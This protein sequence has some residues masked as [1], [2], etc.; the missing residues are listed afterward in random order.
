MAWQEDTETRWLENMSKKGWHLL[1]VNLLQY[2]FIKGEPRDVIYKLD[3]KT[4]RNA[5]FDEYI[6]LFRD[7][8]WEYVAKMNHWIYFR[9]DA[10]KMAGQ[11]I[12][13][14][15]QSRIQKYRS[16]LKILI[17]VSWPTFYFSFVWFP[18]FGYR[19]GPHSTAF[20]AI[21]FFIFCVSII[22]VY[23]AVRIYL[24]IRKLRKLPGQ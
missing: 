22:M 1:D 4:N 19:N 7:S 23:S 3:Y 5:D 14:D 10:Q 12:Y 15:N 21:H 18:I 13:T 17:I 16:L 6:S 8:G 9:A 24:V 2:I 11:D 20:E